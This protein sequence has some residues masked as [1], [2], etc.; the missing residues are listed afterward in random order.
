VIL[1]D[2]SVWVDHLRRGNDAL[3]DALERAVVLTHPFVIGE[4]ALGRMR[5]RLEILHLLGQ[6]PP[7]AEASNREA[8]EL[9]ERRSLMGR[10]IG[11]V[12]LHLIASAALH[13]VPLWTRDRRLAEVARELGLAYSE[14]G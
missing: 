4:L 12:D 1:V 2:S 7:A 11:Y 8:L 6:L 5:N 14:S 3:Q 13:G 9:V 10:G